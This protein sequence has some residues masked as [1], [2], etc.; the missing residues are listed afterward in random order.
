EGDMF[1]T[2]Q[3]VPSI[4]CVLPLYIYKV[5]G[6]HSFTLALSPQPNIK[7]AC[8]C[9]TS[10]HRTLF[11]LPKE[12][13][14]LESGC[15]GRDFLDNHQTNPRKFSKFFLHHIYNRKPLPA[16]LD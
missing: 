4:H 12:R 16:H 7:A 14:P 8:L 11:R 5:D 3:D 1:L 10:V 6:L 9:P 13:H 15:K 2:V